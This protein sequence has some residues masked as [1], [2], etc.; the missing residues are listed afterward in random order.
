MKAMIYT[1]AFIEGFLVI[2]FELLVARILSPYFGGSLFVITAILG[3]TML[4]L[5]LGYYLG[6]Y[7]VKKDAFNNFLFYVILASVLLILLPLI[8]DI[9]IHN[10]DLGLVPGTILSVGCLLGIPLILLGSVSPQLIQLLSLTNKKAGES[11]G[12]IFSISTLGGFIATFILGLYLIVDFGIRTSCY[13]VGAGAM[14][15]TLVVYAFNRKLV[16]INQFGFLIILSLVGVSLQSKN[17]PALESNFKILHQSDGLLGNLQVKEYANNIR[18]LSNNAM[19]QSILNMVDSTSLFHYVHAISSVTSLLPVENRN[20]ALIIGLAGGSLIKELHYLGYKD[21]D[22]VDIDI[23]TQLIANEYF[24]S[25]LDNYNFIVDDG[26]HYINTCDKKYD[27]IIVDVSASEDQPYQLYTSQA[28]E[29]FYSKLNETGFL[30]YNIIDYVNYKKLV[31]TNRVAT[32]LL[33]AG[34]DTRLLQEFHPESDFKSKGIRSI[35]NEKILL[36]IKSK[37]IQN[38][39]GNPASLRHC[40]QKYTFNHKMCEN[41]DLVTFK[42]TKPTQDSYVDD[43]PLMEVESFDKSQLIRKFTKS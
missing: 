3:V 17:Q 10:I 20:N 34:F 32:G 16:N 21:I 18:I 41:F 15:I 8:S 14:I 25:P 19:D 7:L 36:G 38:W 28:I 42:L 1:I 24:L 29:T 39:T 31:I 40:C 35:I 12:L 5:L 6:S 11:S 22:V 4:T 30:I 26:R 37:N 2:A 13:I 43:V 27:V 33:E 9:I 23:R